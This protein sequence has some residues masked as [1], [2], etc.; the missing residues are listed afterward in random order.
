MGV[1]EDYEI[2]IYILKQL[3]TLKTTIYIYIYNI[4][5]IDTWNVRLAAC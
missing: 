1:G 2:D 3:W 5:D 4:Y